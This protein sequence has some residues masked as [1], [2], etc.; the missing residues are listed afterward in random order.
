MPEPTDRLPVAA[1]YA[2][3]STRDKGQDLNN[4]LDQLRLWSA[5]LG[6]EGRVYAESVSGSGKVE[7]KEFDRMIEDARQKRVAIVLFWSLDRFSREG[8]LETLT[9]LNKLTSFGCDWRS[10]TEQYLDST[11]IFR[12]AVIA[13][14]AAVAKQERVRIQ[15]RV[16]AGVDRARKTGTKSG[17]AFGRPQRVYNRDEVREMRAAGMSWRAISREVGQPVTSIRRACA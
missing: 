16:Q 13:I 6:Y 1:I 8:A 4:Q 14:L 9:H 12:D 15:E 11:G 2:R 3:V 5:H 10:Y 17:K 7:R